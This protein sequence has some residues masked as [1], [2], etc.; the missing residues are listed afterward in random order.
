MLQTM[1]LWILARDI[2]A[3]QRTTRFL[4]VPTQ[5]W[6]FWPFLVTK[7]VLSSPITIVLDRSANRAGTP[8]MTTASFGFSRTSPKSP[9]LSDIHRHSPTFTDILRHSPIISDK[10]RQ[11]CS[12]RFRQIPTGSDKLRQ[13]PTGSDI[14][15][16]PTNADK[17]VHPTP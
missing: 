11:T 12:D 8:R 17:T 3:V 14:R 7:T 13:A 2:F 4:Y 9:T 10:L 5:C 1:Q 6:M 16:P 15:Q